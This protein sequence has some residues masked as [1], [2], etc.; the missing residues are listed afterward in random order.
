MEHLTKRFSGNPALDNVEF[1]VGPG[2]IHGLVGH[3]G[4]GKSTLVKVLA[5]VYR[6]T[7]GRILWSAKGELAHGDG[8]AF[9][10]LSGAAVHCVHQDFAIAG[11]LSVIDN[12]CVHR[13]IRSRGGAIARSR[14]RAHVTALLASFGL[15]VD[16]DAPAGSLAPSVQALV[17][18]AR[19][20]QDAQGAEDLVLLDE[21]T[22]YLDQG[23]SAMLFAKVEALAN[24]GATV[25]LVTHHLDEAIKVCRMITVLRDGRH[26]ATLPTVGLVE[27]ELVSL[28]L[29]GYAAG[30]VATR[31]GGTS[32]S[33]GNELL[34]GHNVV[35]GRVRGV[36]LEVR[37]GETVGVA[38][39]VGS[40]ADELPYV[41]YGEGYVSGEVWIGGI[42]V[43]RVTP[44][45][46]WEVGVE[47]VP[48]KRLVE[49]GAGAASVRENLMLHRRRLGRRRWLRWISPR[50]ERMGAVDVLRSFA[51]RPADP[52]VALAVLSGG[53]QQKVLVGR[54]LVARPRVLLLADPTAG[55]DVGAKVEIH[56]AVRSAAKAGCG[57]LVYSS[58]LRELC[59]ICDRVLVVRHGKIVKEM[60]RGTLDEAGLLQEIALT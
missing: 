39:L 58:D 36:S 35:G 5:G 10:P 29:G 32:A 38:G 27:G 11:G 3:N 17:A 53:N 23:A 14:E 51:V 48:T 31:R 60:W 7:S 4:S 8:D 9:G 1:Q 28:M 26:V 25:L 19:A 34:R 52:E 44:R 20:L 59:A 57:V 33:L 12:I 54:R 55:V 42:R 22:S 21:P 50:R 43:T 41:L 24:N 2:E 40:G 37:E 47:L 18:C 56:R 46:V 30:M 13:S 16:L 6:P 49:G 15:S 45:D